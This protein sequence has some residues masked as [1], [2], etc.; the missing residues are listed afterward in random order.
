LSN[1]TTRNNNKSIKVPIKASETFHRF[2]WR[3][4]PTKHLIS[5]AISLSSSAATTISVSC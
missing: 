4:D 5:K 1:N 2:V 3:T